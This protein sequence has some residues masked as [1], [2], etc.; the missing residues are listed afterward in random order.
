MC[1]S[2]FQTLKLCR[3]KFGE[4]FGPFAVK[5]GQIFEHIYPKTPENEFLAEYLCII[6]IIRRNSLNWKKICFY[7]GLRPLV[8]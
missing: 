3:P 4:N 7:G 2:D 1:S 6:K 8:A 5:W